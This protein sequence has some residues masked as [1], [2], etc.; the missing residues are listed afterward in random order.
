V[1]DKSIRLGLTGGIASGKSTV[2]AALA[3]LGACVIDADA[4]S[5]A[6]TSQNGPAVSAIANHFGPTIV[7]D[8]GEIDR[9]RL[10]RLV[11]SMPQ[12]KIALEA[13]IHPIVGQTI[14][15]QAMEAQQL[16]V[17]C[18][19]FDIPLLVET[20]SWRQQ[21]H[22][23]LVVDCT[24]ETQI[25]RVMQRN[26]LNQEDV[27][28]ILAMQA[29]RR[30]RLAAADAVLFNDGISIAHLEAQVSKMAHQFGL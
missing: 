7:N 24:P 30:Q 9:D 26:G 18:I 10:R 23:I 21:L 19:V 5:R 8:V 4:I 13:I 3:K 16:D 11:F 27:V 2:A 14:A 20:G 15:Q 17:P 12:A 1:P 6:A 22:R 28:K 29:P 25:T